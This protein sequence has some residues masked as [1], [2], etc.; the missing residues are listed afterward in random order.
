MTCLLVVQACA[1]ACGADV[2]EAN[3]FPLVVLAC[4]DDVPN[5]RMMA[6]KT[7]KSVAKNVEV[8]VVAKMKPAL[9]KM[10]K[11]SD[12]DVAFFSVDALNFINQIK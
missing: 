7:C 1:Q 3:L 8:S 11:D 12:D 6:A 9:E 2:T 4:T 5:V 10:T